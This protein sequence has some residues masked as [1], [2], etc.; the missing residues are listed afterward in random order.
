MYCGK[1]LDEVRKMHHKMLSFYKE[2]KLLFTLVVMLLIFLNIY[3]FMQIVSVFKPVRLALG[4]VSPPLIA[5]VISFY[6]LKP[7]VDFLER[8]HVSRVFS[9]FMVFAGILIL[10][11]I[12]FLF[13]VPIMNNQIAA[14]IQ[15]APYYW[16]EGLL[17]FQEKVGADRLPD[18][19]NT[20][21]QT[22]LIQ[23]ATRYTQN[24][25]TAA[26]D[27]V[28]SVISVTAQIIITIFTVPFVLYF[29][30][31]DSEKI[32]ERLTRLTPTKYRPTIQRFMSNVDSQLGV[33]VRGQLFVAL[34]V[35]IIF[36]IGYRAIGLNYFLVLAIIAG[37]FNLVP[38]L[39]SFISGCLAVIVAL[40]QDPVLIFY[41]VVVFAIEQILENRVIQPIVL[42][43]QLNM[44][45]ITILFVLLISGNLFGVVG[46]LLGVPT[47]AVIKIILS[48]F[49]E[50]I[51]KTTDLYD[52]NALG[53]PE[54]SILKK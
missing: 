27:G 7:F 5:S 48:M 21:Q 2:N 9:I 3:L 4:I 28:G 47:Y 22:D 17:F 23:S 26:V 31:V 51:E 29:M 45:P 30:L 6:V 49:F 42:G 8:H 16:Q 50:H 40:F 46:L 12:A 13:I 41:L 37:I 14:I 1:L 36:L 33:Y 10:I 44:H 19:L 35:A 54:D 32:P 43:S 18:I 11:T 24:I 53:E 25:L 39:G 20:I 38:Y 34:C 15:E 52:D